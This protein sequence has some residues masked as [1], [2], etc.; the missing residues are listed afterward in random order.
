MDEQKRILLT[1]LLVNRGEDI[2]VDTI[3]G[4]V[5]NSDFVQAAPEFAGETLTKQEAVDI[6]AT[7]AN[8][9]T[10]TTEIDA[11]L[12]N[13]MMINHARSVGLLK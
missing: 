3:L 12:H 2:G 13:A 5:G 10:F 1:N 7:V 11:L 4:L 6:A 9:I 8:A